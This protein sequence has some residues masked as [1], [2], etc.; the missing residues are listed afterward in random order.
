MFNI[1]NYCH[2]LTTLL[3]SGCKINLC[4]ALKNT[5]FISILCYG[6]LYFASYTKRSCSQKNISL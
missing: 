4:K 6:I 3:C 1:S 5:D 2:V